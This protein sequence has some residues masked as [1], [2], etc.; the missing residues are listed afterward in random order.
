MSN[1]KKMEKAIKDLLE[2]M[3]SQ[4]DDVN[5]L[6][7][8][9]MIQQYSEQSNIPS[10]QLSKDLFDE[11]LHNKIEDKFHKKVEKEEKVNEE[12]KLYTN[13]QEAYHDYFKK[14]YLSGRKE[15]NETDYIFYKNIN[16][17][18]WKAFIDSHRL[19]L[20]HRY[21]PQQTKI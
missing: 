11:F 8:K 5:I 17:A 4:E 14:W 7:M 2:I 12:E 13:K 10:L 20:P 9:S 18:I 15:N 19:N 3:F 21:A 6:V 1:I 16:K